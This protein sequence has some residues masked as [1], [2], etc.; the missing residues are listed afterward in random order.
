MLDYFVTMV[1]AMIESDFNQALLNCFLKA[2]Y[3]LIIEDEDLMTKV[4]LI[5]SESER[6][7]EDVENLIN[8]NICMISHFTGVQML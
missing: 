8:H 3:D 7:F 2:H 1:K 5:M 6:N 4:K